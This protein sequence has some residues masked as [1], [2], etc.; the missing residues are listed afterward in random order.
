VPPL[1]NATTPVGIPPE[2]VTAAERVMHAPA[3]TGPETGPRV[4][5]VGALLTVT[6]RAD[7]VDPLKPPLPL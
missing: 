4:V 7:E 1:R 2:E 5:T 6:D 3:S